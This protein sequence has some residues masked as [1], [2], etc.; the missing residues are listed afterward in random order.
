MG[1]PLR[2]VIDLIGGGPNAGRVIKAVMG[3]AATPVVTADQLGTPVSN[4]GMRNVGGMLGCGGFIVFDDHSDMAAVAAGVARFL[5]I[6]SCG[7][8]VPCKEDGLTL[9]RLF[10]R[11]RDS[12]AT[13]DDLAA[14]HACLETV[15][16]GARCTMATQYPLVLH[17]ILD[18]FGDEIEGHLRRTIDAAKPELI[19]SIVDIDG[20]WA[21]LDETHRGKQ[22]DWTFAA[23]WSGKSPA[24]R[25]ST[26]AAAHPS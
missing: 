19:A 17:S 21:Q 7:L 5:S 25:L 22:P 10:D 14:I 8:C 24:D 18:N 15:T 13:D 9:A 20:T 4:E 2:D 26:V 1:T 11:V 23:R 6:E 12:Q 3:G 16:D